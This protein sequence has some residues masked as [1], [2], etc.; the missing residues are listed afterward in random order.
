MKKK[1]SKP[2]IIIED[3]RLSQNIASCGAAHQSDWGS[4]SHWTKATCG[5]QIMEGIIAWTEAGGVCN[6]YYG[7][8]DSIEGVC[9][10]NPEGGTTIFSS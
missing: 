7:E 10:N 9:Y 6:D 4:P 8:N 1:Y 2:G 5:W 3:F